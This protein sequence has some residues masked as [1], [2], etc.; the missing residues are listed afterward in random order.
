MALRDQL[1]NLKRDMRSSLDSFVL[2]GGARFYYD[3]MG[4]ELFLHSCDC[5]HA[6]AEGKPFPEPPAVVKA[7]ARAK[8]RE[9]AFHQVRG[10]ATLDLFPYE[11]VALIERGE[12][13]PRSLVH[14]R[15]LGDGPL[16]DLSEQGD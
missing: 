1:R 8:N 5:L 14:G 2:E 9:A 7:I 6:Q 4:A 10:G 12:I 11:T 16:P 3:P 13:V 15:E